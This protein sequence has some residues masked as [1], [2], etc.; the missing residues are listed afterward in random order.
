MKIN[1]R[2]LLSV[3][4]S[5]AVTHNPAWPKEPISL[6]R[7]VT[8]KPIFAQIPIGGGGY[9]TGMDIAPDGTIVGRVDVFGA[10]LNN[11]ADMGRWT[12]LIT[13]TTVPSSLYGFAKGNSGG[14][15]TDFAGFGGGVYEIRIAPSNTS[16]MYM[17]WGVGPMGVLLVTTN[18]GA[19]WTQ[20]S[21]F[22]SLTNS[23]GGYQNDAN[24]GLPRVF[25][26][27]MA[28]DPN[29]ENILYIGTPV[30]GLYVTT[31]GTSG[32]SATFS[33]VSDIPA[34]TSRNGICAIAFDST[35][36]IMDRATQR[37][38]ACSYGNGVYETTN[39]GSSWA[40]AGSGVTSQCCDGIF[41]EGAYYA[42]T[43][44]G[45]TG[46][47][48]Y[49]NSGSAGNGKW[50]DGGGNSPTAI[51]IN[52]S[53]PTWICGWGN[54][55]GNLDQGVISGTSISWKG[56]YWH[57]G[58]NPNV[59]PS[60]AGWIANTRPGYPKFPVNNWAG[61]GIFFDPT[62][63][64]LPAARIWMSWGYGMSYFD[65][66][67]KTEIWSSEVAL[68]NRVVGIENMVTTQIASAPGYDVVL[69][70]EDN[71]I[72]QVKSLSIPPSSSTPQLGNRYYLSA[73][74][75]IDW[76]QSLRGLIVALSSGYYVGKANYTSYSTD[77]GST[78]GLFS[79]APF[80][81][82]GGD[83]TCAG[84]GQFSALTVGKTSP[85]YWTGNAWAPSSGAPS[86]AYV[87]SKFNN[88]KVLAN[89]AAGSMYL[90]G[91]SIGLYKSINGGQAW[92]KIDGTVVTTATY[93]SALKAVPGNAQYLFYSNGY[94]EGGPYPTGQAFYK[95]I[96][97]SGPWVKVR[98]V[99][100]VFCFG[101]G[102]TYPGYNYPTLWFLGFVNNRG[103][104][105]KWGLW[106]SRDLGENDWTWITD[107]PGGNVDTP[108]CIS[109]DMNDHTKV[110]IGYVGT[111][112][113]YGSGVF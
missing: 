107:W 14:S 102:A 98:N 8:S 54:G 91:P 92:S 78:W 55:G 19:T 66:P 62:K 26:K 37:I 24:S 33:Q 104:G 45:G 87:T 79:R 52:P 113:M 16:V 49:V 50:Y 36:K 75:S 12:P 69:G 6:D 57:S 61:G 97:D 74:W 2:Q 63:N 9:V 51:A 99:N 41:S 82:D 111:S 65:M 48:I 21:K 109:G 5:V 7:G 100:D 96:S 105:Y 20:M 90:T 86:V 1:R 4:G 94:R 93:I 60:D 56:P 44:F 112:F 53:D 89:D 80:F 106:R 95:R 73:T 18:K 29:N 88:T 31:N 39:G 67:T 17:L 46:V 23:N 103:S 110:Y 59:P 85:V 30:N 32:N 64:K 43:G 35:S 42:A 40:E 13:A 15:Y 108:R 11:T 72:F 71:Q 38:I 81:V 47:Q 28:V 27:K 83:I 25:Q 70:I 22:P 3:A 77:G 68:N 58:G 76:S 84:L 101:F 34:G 10:Y